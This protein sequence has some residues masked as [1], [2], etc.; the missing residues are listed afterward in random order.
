MSVEE[1]L[2]AL[3]N[4]YEHP[5]EGDRCVMFAALYNRKE[6]TSLIQ[7]RHKRPERTRVIHKI[8]LKE[9]SIKGLPKWG[10]TAVRGDLN[11]SKEHIRLFIDAIN[12]LD[13]NEIED[14][15]QRCCVAYRDRMAKLHVPIKLNETESL[16]DLILMLVNKKSGGRVQQPLCAASTEILFSSI[17]EEYE[18]RTKKVF[19]GDAQSKALGDI[20][21][22]KSG[23]LVLAIEVKAHRVDDEK[24]RDVLE[25]HGV[26]AYTLLVVGESFSNNIQ[27]RKNFSYCSIRDFAISSI[28]NASAVRGESIEVIS[29]EV[30]E[31]YNQI[32]LE[33]EDMPSL[34]VE[35]P[36]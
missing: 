26:H 31:K 18:V 34:S 6:E 36:T 33:V 19:A 27:S 4:S 32:M 11:D 21:V 12:N 35:L 16:I 5:A 2:S 23:E 1:C 20:Q 15:W 8:L 29:R 13:P 22:H 24:I 25:D 10:A 14:A 28:A 17:G 30:L 7:E 9:F 3:E